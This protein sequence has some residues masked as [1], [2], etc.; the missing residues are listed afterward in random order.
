MGSSLDKFRPTKTTVDSLRRTQL[1]HEDMLK[2]IHERIIQQ[3]RIYA[4]AF[5]VKCTIAV[6]AGIGIVWILKH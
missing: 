3:D 6:G 2:D 4:I 5:N 1:T